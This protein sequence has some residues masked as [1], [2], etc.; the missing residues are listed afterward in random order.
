MAKTED[1]TYKL[2]VWQADEWLEHLEN[3]IDEFSDQHLERLRLIIADEEHMRRH[4][5][6]KPRKSRKPSPGAPE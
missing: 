2:T 5:E 1:G 3:K 4:L 6:G